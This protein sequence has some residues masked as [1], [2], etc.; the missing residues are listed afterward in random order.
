[1]NHDELFKIA[2][3]ILAFR[4][5]VLPE[6]EARRLEAWREEHPE[7]E[8]LFQRLQDDAYLREGILAMEGVDGERAMAMMQ[9]RVR[10][11][12]G[13]VLAA[14]MSAASVVALLIGLFFFSRPG[15][16]RGGASPIVITPGGPHATLELADGSIVL[17]DTLRGG[18]EQGDVA[19]AKS[20]PRQLS[21]LS[22]ETPGDVPPAM[23]EIR[24]PRG[25]E[26]ELVLSDGSRVWINAGSRLRFPVRFPG[27]ERRVFL[28]GEAYFQVTG[29]TSRPFRVHAGDVEVEVLGTSFGV[30]ARDDESFVQAV[31]ERGRVRI[32]LPASGQDV[33]L[34]PDTRAVY[35]KATGRLACSPVKASLFLGWTGGRLVY[36]NVPLE[37]ILGDMGRWYAFEVV[38]TREEARGLSFSLDIKK[39]ASVEEV[40]RL[41][42]ETRRARFS[43]RDGTVYVL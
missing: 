2:R 8:A 38:F 27:G 20:S 32:L 23:N 40:L 3:L 4:E 22:R 6:R 17:L 29:D 19:L 42:E 5:G 21:Y 43:F 39:H 37:L 9:R 7:H 15:E 28:E 13:R 31:L 1:M 33:L 10:A 24:V 14:W 34:E 30:R 35:D 16:S 12:R 18:I 11:R 36:D 41:L 26:F 25:G